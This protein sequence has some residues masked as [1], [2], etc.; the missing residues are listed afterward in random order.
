MLINQIELHAEQKLYKKQLFLLLQMFFST[1]YNSPVKK[2]TSHK[3]CFHVIYKK[4]T[5]VN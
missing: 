2:R 3:H 1:N 5:M 4:C